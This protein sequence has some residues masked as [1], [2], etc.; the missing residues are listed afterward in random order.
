MS[1]GTSGQNGVY[2]TEESRRGSPLVEDT[3]LGGCVEGSAG[4]LTPN[5]GTALHPELA[6]PHDAHG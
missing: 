6:A 5:Q 2:F 3:Q 1:H 4:V